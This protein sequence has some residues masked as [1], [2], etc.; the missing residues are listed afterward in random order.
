[1]RR[2]SRRAS[3]LGLTLLEVLV[4]IAVIAVLLAILL[5]GLSVARESGRG[6]VCASN[7]RQLATANELYASDFE[8]SYAPAAANRLGNLERWHGRRAAASQAFEPRD[9]SLAPYFDAGSLGIGRALRA[10]P[11]FAPALEALWES[12]AGFERGCGGYGYN[13]AFVGTD[14]TPERILTRSTGAP[15]LAMGVSQVRCDA[16]GSN[17]AR[18]LSPSGTVAF[19]DAALASESP[20]GDVVEYSFLEPRLHPHLSSPARPDPS[21][22]FRHQGR[23]GVG[24]ASVAWL[25]GHVSGERMAFSWSSG[26]YLP[27]AREVDIGWFGES[28]DNSVFDYR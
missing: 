27:E 19:A 12:G 22:H 14:R 13:A 6:T 8:G 7:S 16:R 11:T 20:A 2:G 9:G 3:R 5:P 10:C 15:G 23:G 17:R 4:V 24:R 18:F 21:V 26:L 25:D 28:D 1:M